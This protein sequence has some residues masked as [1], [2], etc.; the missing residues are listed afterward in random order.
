MNERIVRDNET[1]KAPIRFMC[2]PGIKPVKVPARIPKIKKKINWI[3]TN[4][5]RFNN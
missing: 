1:K 4:L 5:E 3:N 2:I